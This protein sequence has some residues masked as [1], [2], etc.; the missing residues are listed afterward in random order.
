MNMQRSVHYVTQQHIFG[1][2][3][4]L[5]RLTDRRIAFYE[6]Q[7]HYG[8]ERRKLHLEAMKPKKT[9]KQKLLEIWS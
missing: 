8:E 7:G 2:A 3:V 5:G 4:P 1:L 9:T 6:K